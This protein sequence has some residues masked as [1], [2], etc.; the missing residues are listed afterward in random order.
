MYKNTIVVYHDACL[1]GMASRYAAWK[2]FGWDASYITGVHQQVV[3]LNKFKGKDV[4]CVDFSYK[5]KDLMQIV[6]VC[7]SMRIL[8]HHKTAVPEIEATLE[9][10]KG[11]V[12]EG[13]LSYT[14]SEERSGV[15][16]VWD[17]YHKG[18]PMPR[19]LWHIEDRDIW[20]F[21]LPGT[22]EICC[23]MASLE[24]D[25]KKWIKHVESDNLREIMIKGAS[26][27]NKEAQ[28]IKT[29]TDQAIITQWRGY[30]IA[31]IENCPKQYVS[32]A[33]N[34]LLIDHTDVDFAANKCWIDDGWLWSFRSE[35]SRK[36]VGE[37]AKSIGGGG[38]RNAS[39]ALLS[40][41]DRI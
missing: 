39:G 17:T 3:N 1:D 33:C 32:E 29:I 21:N 9:E 40:S 31:L 41:T 7:K 35:D 10:L 5:R 8:D 11:T 2:K 26:I 34:K 18:L 23:Y 27:R 13:K 25:F 24:G 22:V 19:I 15:G 20:A 4:V 14:Y 16:V 37:I 38:H 28:D 6:K 12:H 30:T 36:D